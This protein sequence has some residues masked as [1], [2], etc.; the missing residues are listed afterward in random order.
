MRHKMDRAYFSLIDTATEAVRLST[1]IA[2]N[3]NHKE[4]IRNA[5]DPIIVDVCKDASRL[6]RTLQDVLNRQQHY[7]D[8]S[9]S[10]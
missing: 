7:N 4:A 8:M 6:L 10:E 3:A 2:M 1:A 9:I 5:S